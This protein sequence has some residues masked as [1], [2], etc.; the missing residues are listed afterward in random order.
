MFWA[1][2]QHRDWRKRMR[3]EGA[4]AER[5]KIRESLKAL[6]RGRTTPITVEEVREL[7]LKDAARHCPTCGQPVMEG[8][9]VS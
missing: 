8:Q 4:K 7:L 2:Q 9:A 1:L 5:D 3:E 6:E